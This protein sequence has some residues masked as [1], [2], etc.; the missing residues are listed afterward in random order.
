M[1]NHEHHGGHAQDDPAEEIKKYVHILY[2]RRWLLVAVSLTCM[3]GSLVWAK[4]QTP[5]YRA[6][7]S[8]L[9]EP[10]LAESMKLVQTEPVRWEEELLKTQM[11]VIRSRK[12][13]GEAYRA[14]GMAGQAMPGSDQIESFRR[15][16]EVK[17]VRNTRIFRVSMAHSDAKEASRQVNILV[18]RY[19]AQNLADRREVSNA[20]FMWLSE[21]LASMKQKLR[22]SEMTLLRYK[23]DENIV[24]LEKS[25]LMLERRI[26]EKDVA[27]TAALGR[28]HHLGAVLAEISGASAEVRNVLPKD[29]QS[30]VIKEIQSALNEVTVSYAQST[31]VY[32]PKHPR[33]VAL[34]AQLSTLRGQLNRQIDQ[35]VDSLEMERDISKSRATSLAAELAELKRNS[36]I[37]AKQAVQ[38]D[39]L[40]R[41]AGSNLKLFNSLLGRLKE[42][43]MEGN[44]KANNVR[45]LD[46]AEVPHRT[47]NRGLRA[48]LVVGILL[49]IILG[50]GLCLVL[51]IYDDSLDTEDDVRFY[52][53]QNTFALIP[54]EKGVGYAGGK[55]SEAFGRAFREFRLALERQR[56]SHQLSTLMITS[57]QHGEGKSTTVLHLGRTLAQWGL[58]IL[59]VDANL[60]EPGLSKALGK[61]TALG[62]SNFFSGEGTVANLILGTRWERLTI[63]PAGALPPRPYE[64]LGSAK[65]RLLLEEVKSKFDLILL[66]TPSVTEVPEVA[67]MGGY[68]DGILV[69]ARAGKTSRFEIAKALR[70]LTSF[71]R[72]ILGVV[73]TAADTAS[74]SFAYLDYLDEE[75]GPEDTL[76]Y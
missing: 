73:L 3:V 34:H 19:L 2:R 43:D 38:Y 74:S 16:I 33:M 9:I 46:S 21:Q 37:L 36:M 13:A 39:V 53:Q 7:A 68:A 32:K 67:V 45:V 23:E 17:A 54:M 72:H 5:T 69:V 27:Y 63:L 52:L 10:E 22:D 20:A 62:L 47:S 66:D 11:E 6:T 35:I 42:V 18:D 29:L 64:L 70:S 15:G 60:I 40:D 12:V 57:A 26:G 49:S 28:A 61:E 56:R 71:N 4:L 31:K 1:N 58:K 76:T 8:L 50:A 75:Q 51:E 65:I 25:R 55:S 44:T 30:P 48:S 41:E 14:L 59:L 24:S